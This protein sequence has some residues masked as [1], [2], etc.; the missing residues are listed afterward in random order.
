MSRIDEN[1]P[2]IPV[3]IAILTVS[4]TRTL[5]DDKSGRTLAELLTQAGHVLA[6]RV[7]VPDDKER[8][9]AQLPRFPVHG[10]P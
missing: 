5:A 2:F 3:R 9:K 1:R 6:D 4:D 7:I 8:I 10:V